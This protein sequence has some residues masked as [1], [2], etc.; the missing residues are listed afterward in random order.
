M[1]V[2]S[3]IEVNTI[4][5]RSPRSPLEPRIFP[6]LLRRPYR[7]YRTRLA[8]ARRTALELPIAISRVHDVAPG[9]GVFAERTRVDEEKERRARGEEEQD[10]HEPEGV[11]EEDREESGG[12]RRVVARETDPPRD[13]D[14][15]HDNRIR[16][17]VSEVIF[18]PLVFVLQLVKRK[19]VLT[20]VMQGTERPA[21]R[22][23][24]RRHSSQDGLANAT[25]PSTISS[26]LR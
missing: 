17:G 25:E 8:G 13:A 4:G 18:R 19:L 9:L 12:V 21:S 26:R 15:K 3:L 2:S 24:L 10:V 1:S 6:H 16:Y 7:R 5:P 20:Q 14:R 22:E 11:V 23:H